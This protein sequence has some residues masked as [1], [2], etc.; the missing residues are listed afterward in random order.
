MIK[1]IIFVLV[2]FLIILSPLL[3]L[4]NPSLQ[5]VQSFIDKYRDKS[6][7]PSWQLFL[8]RTYT[9]TFRAEEGIKTYELFL[10]RY[11]KHEDFIQIKFDYCMA[12]SNIKERK[13]EAINAF[14]E[15]IESY[16]DHSLTPSAAKKRDQ[17]IYVF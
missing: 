11:P 4:S 14:N 13:Q 2:L 8:A 10:T 1:K 7:A 5:F 6:W 12:I 3:F 15:F 9:A 17:L 16:P